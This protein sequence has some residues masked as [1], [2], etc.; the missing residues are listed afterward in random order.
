MVN[1]ALS[2][3]TPQT[4]QTPLPLNDN[5]AWC[6]FQDERALIDPANNTLLLGSV[7]SPDGLQ[8][9]ERG[10]NIEITVLDLATGTSR[11]H[12]LHEHLE[13]DDHN[14]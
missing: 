9:A 2:P 12:V 3:Q 13:A 6:W 14:A 8:G 1:D 4:L 10:G 7:A 5:G 11:I